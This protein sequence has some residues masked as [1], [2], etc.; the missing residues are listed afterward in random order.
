MI[1][2][3][4]HNLQLYS[5]AFLIDENF[6]YEDNYVFVLD[7]NIPLKRKVQIKGTVDN[8]LIIAG[9]IFDGEKIIVTRL[10][11]LSGIKKLYSKNKNAK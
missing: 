6:I 9:E 4:D 5:K 8:K 3:N 11:N 7:D 1:S 2:G 10:T